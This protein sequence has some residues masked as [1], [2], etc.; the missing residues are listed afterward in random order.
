MN[1]QR[2]KKQEVVQGM[3]RE[4]ARAAILFSGGVDSSLVLKLASEVLKENILA[5]TIDSPFISRQEID[6]A[7]KLAGIIGVEHIVVSIDM[8]NDPDLIINPVERCYLC[9][10]KI[11]SLAKRIADQRG[12]ACVVDGT[13]DQDSKLPRPGLRAAEESG[14]RSPLR[15]GGFQKDDVRLLAKELGLPNWNKP[16]NSCLA[17]RFPFGEILTRDNLRRIEQ[18]ERLLREFGL[19]CFRLRYHGKMGT[20]GNLA[21]IHASY[22][23]QKAVIE[24]GS[25]IAKILKE[26]GFATVTLDIE[27]Y[28]P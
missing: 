24:K 26:V 10:K 4:I 25:Q 11:F 28:Y 7:R 14:V 21:R 9:K 20:S 27:E 2:V 8:L 15:E 18:G 6:E 19:S 17:T 16:S 13:N 23:D 22:Q 5:I 1:E 3:L 12:L